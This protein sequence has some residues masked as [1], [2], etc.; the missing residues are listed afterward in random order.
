[1][2][3][4]T[5]DA[6]NKSARGKRYIYAVGRR[7]EA[8]ATVRLFENKARTKDLGDL[9]TVNGLPIKEYFPGLVARKAYEKPFVVGK[10]LGKFKG[11]LRVVGGGKKGQLQAVVLAIS[12]ALVKYN[13][14][15]YRPLMRGIGLLTVDYRTRERRKAGQMGRAR[16]KKQ[17][18]KR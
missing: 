17:S 2:V 1:M 4:K 10:C 6:G 16:K 7:K 3:K 18:P 11:W 15:V 13:P 9:F 12:R 14:E 8:V 5:K